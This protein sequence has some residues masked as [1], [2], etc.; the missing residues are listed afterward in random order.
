MIDIRQSFGETFAGV[1]F[2]ETTDGR[3]Q[4]NLRRRNQSNTFA[5]GIGATV[6]EAWRMALNP[7]DK[8]PIRRDIEDLL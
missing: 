3:I 1:S 6:E 7:L 4:C 2:W 5:V 8:K